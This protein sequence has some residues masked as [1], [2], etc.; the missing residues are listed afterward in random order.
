MKFKDF[1]SRTDK[2]IERAIRDSFKHSSLYQEFILSKVCEEKGGRG[3]KRWRC[4]EC[5]KLL[6]GSKE[7]DV[8][9]VEPVT[10]MGEARVNMDIWKFYSRTF[11][12]YENLQ[13]LCKHCHKTKSGKENAKRWTE[14]M[15]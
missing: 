8:D 5:A 4:N 9:H 14:L 15:R 3:G 7:F 13:I 2:Y 1:D 12:S 10:P 11:C 6:A